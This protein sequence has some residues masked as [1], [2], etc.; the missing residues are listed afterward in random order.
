MSNPSLRSFSAH[1]YANDF[2]N[3]A[4]PVLT[5][6]FIF[7]CSNDGARG[8]GGVGGGV[9]EDLS[10]TVYFFTAGPTQ[11]YTSQPFSLHC[12]KKFIHAA[13]DHHGSRQNIRLVRTPSL[14]LSNFP[15]LPFYCTLF[16]FTRFPFPFFRV[17]PPYLPFFSFPLF[18]LH[19]L[20]VPIFTLSLL[21]CFS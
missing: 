7:Y 4:N 17:S 10:L 8:A 6:W 15:L 11:I 2:A 18:S 14:P 1:S 9:G 16:I 20:P 3:P 5:P 21:S 19:V 13:G 12:N